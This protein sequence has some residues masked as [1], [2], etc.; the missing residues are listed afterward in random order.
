MACFDKV[1][2]FDLR[3]LKLNACNL[4]P[5]TGPVGGLQIMTTFFVQ[6][7][8]DAGLILASPG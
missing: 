6:K 3:P 1:L 2:S 7:S 4:E 8:G 5:E